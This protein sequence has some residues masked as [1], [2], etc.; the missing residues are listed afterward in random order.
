MK[1]SFKLIQVVKKTAALCLLGLVG[2]LPVG[3]NAVIKVSTLHVDFMPGEQ[4]FQ[5]VFIQNVGTD[6]EYVDVSLFKRT[7]PVKNPEQVLSSSGQNP[8]TF[9]MVVTPNKLA[10]SPGQTKRIRLLNLTRGNKTDAV[11]GVRVL[12][13]PA[14]IQ[15]T[16]D[17]ADQHAAGQVEIISAFVVGV[18]VLP[19]HPHVDLSL[20]RTGNQLVIENKGNTNALLDGG[21]QCTS[22]SK[23][24]CTKVEPVRIYG[25]SKVQITLA[26]SLPV[27]YEASYLDKE[28]KIVSN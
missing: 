3:A 25:D 26:K 1:L 27:T 6:V 23:P 20:T 8:E 24:V 7:D 12:P 18:Y 4:Q 13:V 14:P 10:I 21:Q 16:K 19:A 2:W 28:E 11:Y 5:D 17:N 15:A 22:D 9:G